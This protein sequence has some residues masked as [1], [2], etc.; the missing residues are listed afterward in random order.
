MAAVDYY[1]ALGIDRNSG[2]E[3]IKKAYRKLALK[4]HPDRNP[5][6]K[7][8]EESFKRINEAYACLSDPEKKANYDR[9]GS[10]EGLA[11]M[12][13]FGAGA[14]FSGGFGDVFEDLFGEMF[15]AFS[16][17]R[18]GPRPARGA[19]LRYDLEVS[20][21]EAAFGAEREIKVPRWHRCD[22][23]DGSGARHGTAPKACATCGGR[24]EIRMQQG[25]FSIARTCTKCGGAGSVITDPC[26]ECRG[27]GRVRRE[28]TVSVKLPAGVDSG[29]RLK[30]TAEGELGASGGPPG[31]LYIVIEVKDHKVFAREG[32]HIICDQ[33]ITF[34]QA[35][36]GA[37]LGIPTLEGGKKV[38]L[39]VPPGT[40]SHQ[41]FRL[42]GKGITNLH[43]Q[44]R[45][46]QIVRV[47]IQVPR[48]LSEKQKSLLREFADL[49]GE[50]SYE[51]TRSF[52]DRIE[53]K[54]RDFF[55][56]E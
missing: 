51:P 4:Y 44:G 39:R 12:G 54:V 36:L 28:R 42:K 2:D 8:A 30:M 48:K 56:G 37:E 25:F 34:T 27:Q 32:D 22:E 18:R 14:G 1:E 21:E 3:A 38:K 10:P 50:P 24:G 7:S 31:D 11:G 40:R 52:V 45:G 16:G 13:G 43:G 23:C 41:L 55:S 35:A 46:D 29:T 26:P 9:Y 5:G 53:D 49:T 15:G 47:V 33:P 20:L 17:A 6:D 19:D